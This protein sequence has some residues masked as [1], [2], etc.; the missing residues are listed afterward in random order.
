MSSDG[1]GPLVVREKKEDIGSLLGGQE[2]RKKENTGDSGGHGLA[3]NF[4]TVGFHF[5]VFDKFPSPVCHVI[6][7]TKSFR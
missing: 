2:S 1:V 3:G 4:L 5:P 6:N 7:T